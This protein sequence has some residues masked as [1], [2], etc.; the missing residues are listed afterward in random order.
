[1]VEEFIKKAI[2]NVY[3]DGDI[4]RKKNRYRERKRERERKKREKDRHI[5]RERLMKVIF[6]EVYLGDSNRQP[7]PSR[8]NLESRPI[9]PSQKRRERDRDIYK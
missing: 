2:L 5:E 7:Q 3:G 1:M 4:E 9:L 6:V 8:E